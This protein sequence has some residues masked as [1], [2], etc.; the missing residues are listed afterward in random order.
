MSHSHH[1]EE[2]DERI[3]RKLL[4]RLVDLSEHQIRLLRLIA[5]EDAPP[6]LTDIKIQF[7]KGTSMPTPGPITLTTVGATA[8][9][10]VVGFDQFGAPWT[11][12]IPPVTYANGSDA[13]ATAVGNG[14]G[15]TA[16]VTAVANG[17]DSLTASLTTAEGLALTDV[18]T[19]TVAIS[20]P[21]P[22]VLSSI[23]IAF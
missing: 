8:T 20:A 13:V 19:V 5:K 22:P 21:P 15:L 4:E 7:S 12:P 3:E 18:E 17:V 2:H 9:A 6:A 16:L 11:G 1:S 23:K 10:T 14:D